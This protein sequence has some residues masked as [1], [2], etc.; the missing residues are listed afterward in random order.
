MTR[1]VPPAATPPFPAAAR[2]LTALLATAV[3]LAATGCAQAPAEPAPAPPPIIVFDVDTL[4]ADHLGCYGYRRDTS[5]HIDR[6]A[7]RAVR[8]E[9]AFSQAPT[10]PPSQA[11]ILTGLYPSSHGLLGHEYRLGEEIV[12]L[13]ET[14]RARGYATGGFV[15]GGY[16]NPDF[17]LG[18]GFDRYDNSR[19]RGLKRIAPRAMHWL[20]RHASRPFLLL[21][22]TYDVHTPYAPP[23]PYRSRFLEGIER[24]TP[25]FEPTVEEMEAVRMSKYGDEPRTLSPGDLAYAEALYDGGIAFVDAW[26]GELLAYVDW[27]GLGER[28]VI[29]LI[30]D[31][32]EEFQEHGSVL[33]E[34]LYATV[35][36]IPLL[37]R[38]PG[39][40]A[41]VHSEIVES[42]DLT[43]TLLELAGAPA[44]RGLEGRSLLPLIAGDRLRQAPVAV[45]ESRFF[46]EQRAV[47]VG[48]HRLIY[49]LGADVA[50]LYRFR[51]DPL[52]QRDLA[53]ERPGTVARLL[54]AIRGWDA[55]VSRPPPAERRAVLSDETRRQLQ[56]LGYLR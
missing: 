12:T 41:A 6:F 52:E 36:R 53:A 54:G 25:G 50:E 51:D 55:L 18:Q 21:I 46:G 2:R 14:L 1:D 43:P 34:K 3:A 10:T 47:S 33:H 17:G 5:P 49:T 22:H 24:S 27:L 40:G 35:T 16:M 8:F 39:R 19:G 32:G 45:G 48:E 4:R 23:E 11:S 44:P 9:W 37:I 38:L 20:R 13:A 15:D 42:I 56:A 26:F 30:S 29:V 7:A 28:A 31:H